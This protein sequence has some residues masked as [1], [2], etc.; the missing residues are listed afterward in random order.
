MVLGDWDVVEVETV[1]VFGG[2][3]VEVV[4][5]FVDVELV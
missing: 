4:F 5:D 1:W 3:E 2:G